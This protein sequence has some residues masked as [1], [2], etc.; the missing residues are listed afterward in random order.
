M[1]PFEG[2]TAYDNLDIY[3]ANAAE[4]KIVIEAGRNLIPKIRFTVKDSILYIHNDNKDNWLR[5]TGNP[6]IRIGSNS[7]KNINIYGYNN[8][9]T[10]DTLVFSSLAIFSDGTGD[11]RIR[12]SGDSLRVNSTFVSNFYLSG[13]TKYLSVSLTYDSQFHGS[14]LCAGNVVIDHSGSNEVEV[15]PEFSLLGSLSG[16][17]NL[18]YYHNPYE[19]EMKISG[20]GK[21]VQR[22]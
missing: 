9:I 16:T 2:I 12:A 21:L 13:Q 19:I 11:V 14:T 1:P 20:T 18:Y 7:V 8:V 22:F 17:G 15:F 4:Q 6:V 10:P 3:L 5:Q